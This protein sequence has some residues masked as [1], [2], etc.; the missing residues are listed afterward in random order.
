[1]INKITK[2]IKICLIYICLW[3]SSLL[4]GQIFNIPAGEYP[5]NQIIEWKGMGALLLN[6][7]LDGD[8]KKFNLTLVGASATGLWTEG[9]FPKDKD[10]YLI[11]NENTRYLYFIDDFDTE[12]GTIS[13]TQLN[14]AGSIKKYKV[15]FPHAIREVGKYSTRE[16]KLIDV[17]VTDKAL[18]YQFRY[19]DQQNNCFVDLAVFIV[20]HSFSV[21]AQLVGE[22]Y[23]GELRNRT[24]GHWR[25]TGSDEDGI[26][27]AK[28]KTRAN[29]SGWIVK[30]FSSKGV[31]EISNYVI[32]PRDDLQEIDYVGIGSTGR[33]YLAIDT[34]R[35]KGILHY[36]KG[37]YYTSG[38]IP[39]DTNNLLVLYE[40]KSNK[41]R[42]K[43]SHPISRV[44]NEKVTLGNL[45]LNEGIAYY[46]N[47][48]EEGKAILLPFNKSQSIVTNRFG[49]YAINN[50]SRFIVLDRPREFVAVLPEG[51]LYFDENQLNQPG[52]MVFELILK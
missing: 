27:F 1:M 11:S 52:G 41:W 10:F 29:E 2:N 23:F 9:F 46:L 16:L 5:Y 20:H 28:E 39:N 8:S 35:A 19:L 26:Y 50:P 47:D 30:G 32:F 43:S 37:I 24:E 44:E 7:D 48:G 12:R 3:S 21:Y 42:L 33:N 25:Y 34:E 31:L 22:T 4:Y 40:L 36:H 17:V 14:T 13:F 45:S 49:T 6:R 18:V 15:S 51:Y 38:I